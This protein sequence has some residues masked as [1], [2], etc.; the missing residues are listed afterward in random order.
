MSAIWTRRRLEA[1]GKSVGVL[2]LSMKRAWP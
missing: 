1:D 2:G